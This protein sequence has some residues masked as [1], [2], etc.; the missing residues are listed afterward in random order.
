MNRL[1]LPAPATKQEPLTEETAPE[2]DILLALVASVVAEL[3]L[4]LCRVPRDT[5]G[6][7]P[8]SRPPRSRQRREWA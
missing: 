6:T 1:L 3:L 2:L 7:N 8:P 4:V 5:E